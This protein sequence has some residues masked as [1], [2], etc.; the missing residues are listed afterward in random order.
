MPAEGTSVTPSV[1]RVH[2]AESSARPGVLSSH[3][4]APRTPEAAMAGPGRSAL[5]RFFLPGAAT[6]RLLPRRDAGA[7]PSTVRSKGPRTAAQGSSEPEGGRD[8][9]SVSGT[10]AS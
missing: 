7:G 9:W 8:G 1:H 2:Q 4:A 3:L 10:Q 6:C 5:G